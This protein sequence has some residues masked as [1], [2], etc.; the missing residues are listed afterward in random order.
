MMN[1][2]RLRNPNRE[3]EGTFNSTPEKN[4]PH[5]AAGFR[6]RLEDASKV[7]CSWGIRVMRAWWAEALQPEKA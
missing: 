5:P 3:I 2:L 6:K 1:R 4:A 7:D